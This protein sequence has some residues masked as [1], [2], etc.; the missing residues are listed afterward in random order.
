[1]E[2][3]MGKEKMGKMDLKKVECG[4]ECGFMVR[5]HDDKELIDMTVKHVKDRHH[6]DLSA[7]EVKGMMKAVPMM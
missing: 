1:M 7:N 6:Q 5:S 2:K 3:M 4:P